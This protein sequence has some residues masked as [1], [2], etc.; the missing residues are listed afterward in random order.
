MASKNL[1]VKLVM[2]YGETLWHLIGAFTFVLPQFYVQ[3][4]TAQYSTAQY[5]TAHV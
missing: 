3:Y 5:S 4:S 1:A 2:E